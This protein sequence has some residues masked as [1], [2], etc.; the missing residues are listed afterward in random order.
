MDLIK[1][2]QGLYD[3]YAALASKDQ[4]TVYFCTDTHQI[5]LGAEEYTKST[6][7]LSGEPT[8]A[9][10]GDAG[11][12]YA[13]NGN[14]YL[15]SG[16]GETAGTYVWTRVANINDSVAT[17]TSIEVGE[18][19]TTASGTTSITT[20]DTIEHAVPTGATTVVDPTADAAPAFGSTFAIQGVETDKFGHVTGS[21]TRTITLPTESPVT[22]AANA[23]GTETLAFG[24]TF[25][26]ITE[27]A[28]D[29][30]DD[31]EV[32]KTTTIFTLPV[33][34]AAVTYDISSPAEG[35]ISLND[36]ESGA[37]TV[38]IN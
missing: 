29:A 18:G 37:S 35:V 11:R 17:V 4:Y 33:V 3:N 28:M 5:F 36:S 25:A 31:H 30:S 38:A 6:R 20:T 19:L 22:V 1:L 23:D 27:V 10:Q 13:Y 16:E 34:P 21:N 26:A 7:V 2:G 12:L 9:T 32:E 14:L 8:A 24:S 15:C